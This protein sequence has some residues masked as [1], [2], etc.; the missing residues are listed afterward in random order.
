MAGLNVKAQGT[1][2]TTDDRL[3]IAVEVR[4]DEGEPVVGLKKS[5]F[6]VW[7]LGHLFG[8]LTIDIVVSLEEIAGLEG[9]YHVVKKHWPPAVNGTFA[10]V[11]KV[12]KGRSSGQAMTWVVKVDGGPK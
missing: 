8:A 4:N 12:S 2:I 11:V 7:Q 3:I 9:Y 10:F 1:E 5:S 6:K